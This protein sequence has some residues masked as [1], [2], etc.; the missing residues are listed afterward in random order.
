MGGPC[1][2]T[3]APGDAITGAPRRAPTAQGN[4]TRKIQSGVTRAPAQPQNRTGCAWPIPTAATSR[5]RT[6]GG[7]LLPVGS[8][9]QRDAAAG[10]HVV[11]A[12]VIAAQH[13]L[14]E[15][16]GVDVA[17]GGAQRHVQVVARTGRSPP[18]TRP[19][20]GGAGSR[21]SPP[22]C[23]DSGS[24]RGSRRRRGRRSPPTGSP[25][26]KAAKYSRGTRAFSILARRRLLVCG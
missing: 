19:R 8:R 22:P 20:R 4:R 18:P 24:R 1:S 21:P 5:L 16:A 2:P 23:R 7:S 15:I 9:R 3:R 14:Q 25:A 11:A 13:P 17:V 12:G 6:P 10:D 26:R